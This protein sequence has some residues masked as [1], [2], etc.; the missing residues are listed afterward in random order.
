MSALARGDDVVHYSP[1]GSSV[2]VGDALLDAGSAPKPACEE[3]FTLT[4][5][6]AR[7]LARS[8]RGS[9]Y[10]SGGYTRV[11]ISPMTPCRSTERYDRARDEWVKCADMVSGEVVYQATH[12]ALRPPTPSP[13]R[14]PKENCPRLPSPPLAS[15]V[16]LSTPLPHVP[17]QVQAR[18]DHHL[19]VLNGRLYSVGGTTDTEEDP[20]QKRLLELYD[21]DRD[22]W[23]VVDAEGQCTTHCEIAFGVTTGGG[24]DGGADGPRCSILTIDKDKQPPPS[25]S[26]I[27][28]ARLIGYPKGVTNVVSIYQLSDDGKAV[29]ASSTNIIEGRHADWAKGVIGHDVI[30]PP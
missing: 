25:G 24:A 8:L 16:L 20:S 10:V 2:L 6:P 21:A 27:A 1:A 15:P 28:S 4:H 11:S 3:R 30:G 14:R 19:I 7:S 26:S 22:E 18:V 12:S 17:P 23:S 13:T 5:P 29:V 9:L